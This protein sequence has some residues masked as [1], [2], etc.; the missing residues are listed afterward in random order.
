MKSYPEVTFSFEGEDR[1]LRSLF[2]HV[3]R[4][5][6]V[7]VGCNDPVR[8]NNTYLFYLDGWDGIAIDA[9]QEYQDR[10]LSVRPRDRF[11]SALVS[12]IPEIRSFNVFRDRTMSSV[13]SETVA[14]YAE[15][16]GEAEKV[17][18]LP[19][20]TLSYLIEKNLPSKSDSEIHLVTVDV[21]GWDLKV[22][23]GLDFARHLPGCIVVETKGLNLSRP[24]ENE[25]SRYLNQHGYSFIAKTPLDSFFV[26]PNKSYFDWIPRQL[27]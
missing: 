1:I 10:W 11:L 17:L 20:F 25:I 5:V 26:H 8:H 22:L 18:D 27:L 3:P 4:G 7:D 12:N 23:Q 19:A 21:E 2:R 16:L 15:R 24:Y 6:Y 14:R 9:N 13:D